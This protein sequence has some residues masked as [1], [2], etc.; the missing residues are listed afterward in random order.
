MNAHGDDRAISV[1]E[2]SGEDEGDRGAP[3]AGAEQGDAPMTS[4]QF[5][6]LIGLLLELGLCCDREGIRTRSMREVLLRVYELIERAR[7]ALVIKRGEGA[8]FQSTL[9]RL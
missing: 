4:G 8:V 5:N 6:D 2:E 7:G 9:N 1:S 3:A